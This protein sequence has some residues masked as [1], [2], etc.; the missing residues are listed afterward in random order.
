MLLSFVREPVRNGNWVLITD[1]VCLTVSRYS[2]E[3][4][5]Q[6]PLKALPNGY[7]ERSSYALC[8]SFL[9]DKE[10]NTVAMSRVSS[11]GV[12]EKSVISYKQFASKLRHLVQS[13]K[14][15]FHT[16]FSFEVKGIKVEQ[17]IVVW[18]DS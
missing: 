7:L 13:E 16:N 9:V 18:E 11:S 8:Y 12:S 5:N 6:K 10:E 4:I 17:V 15:R 2:N 14:Y 1:D 3:V